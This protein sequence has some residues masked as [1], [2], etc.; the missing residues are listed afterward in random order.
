LTTQSLAGY[1]RQHYPILFKRIHHDGIR[2]ECI[3]NEL[4]QLG[5]DCE[6][7]QVLRNAMARAKKKNRNRPMNTK[8]IDLKNGG[9]T[10]LYMSAAQTDTEQENF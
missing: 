9:K 4:Q 6:N 3:V 7:V 5:F 2:Q 1:V 10:F 8:A